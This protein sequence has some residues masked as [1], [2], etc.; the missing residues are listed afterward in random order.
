[1]SKAGLSAALLLQVLLLALPAA[2]AGQKTPAVQAAAESGA[3]TEP[4]YFLDLMTRE[5]PAE[6]A[7]KDAAGKQEDGAAAK[8][9]GA[10]R[11]AP[12]KFVDIYYGWASTD[13]SNVSASYENPCFLFCTYDLQS[14]QRKVRFDSSNVFGIRIGGWLDGYPSIGLAA[15]FSYLQARAPGVTIWYVPISFV[16]LGRYGFLRTD[17]LPEGRVQ[18]YGGL[19]IS[20]VIGDIE[21]DFRPQMTTPVG[22]FTFDFNL[23]GGLLLGAAWHFPSYA[24]FSEFRMMNASLEY[25]VSGDDALFGGSEKAKADLDTKQIV[26]GVSYKF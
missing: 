7:G 13:D 5:K 21:V 23:A 8:T 20:E 26:I 11:S 6:P 14:A 9:G 25:D 24:L 12:T 22:G 17:A 1:M 3:S 16:V 10:R 19:M 4:P 18:I 15:D 2:G